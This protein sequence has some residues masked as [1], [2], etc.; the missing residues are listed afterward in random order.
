MSSVTIKKVKSRYLKDQ[1]SD[2]ALEKNRQRAAEVQSTIEQK[3]HVNSPA[4]TQDSNTWQQ[5]KH[6]IDQFFSDAKNFLTEARTTISSPTYRGVM[7]K[8]TRVAD[9]RD[10]AER[11]DTVVSYLNKNRNFLSEDYYN[12]AMAD[13]QTFRKYRP[14][15]TDGLRK[16]QDYFSQFETEDV[17]NQVMQQQKDYTDM[18]NYDTKAGAQEI[19]Q[20]EETLKEYNSLSRLNLSGKWQERFDELTA[21][22]GDA[23]G[24]KDLIS[25]KR[26]YLTQAQRLQESARLGSVG[27]VES[28][29]YDPS[30]AYWAGARDYKIPTREQLEKYDTMMDPGTW[31]FTDDGRLVDS[32]GNEIDHKNVDASG[33][34]IHPAASGGGIARDKLGIFLAAT[35]D[36]M[37]AA[38][39]V[40]DPARTSTWS[41]IITE[42]DHKNWRHLEPNEVNTYYYYLNKEGV[43]AAERYLDSLQD[44]LNYREGTAKYNLM[45]GKTGRE[46]LYGVEAGLDQ[47]AS[48]LRGVGN[49]ARGR[50]EYIPTT[51]TQY[52]SGMVRE[53]LADNGPEMPEWLGG[54]S[55]GQG[56]YDAITTTSNML[57]SILTSYAANAV[58]PGSGGVIGTGLL[59]ASAGGNAYNEM[60]NR[61]YDANQSRTYA[62][63]IGASE[64]GLQAVLGGISQFGGGLMS[65][66]IAKALGRVDNAIAR[67]AIKLGNTKIGRVLINAIEEGSEE[68]VQAIIE[69]WLQNVLLG[70]ENEID[71]LSDEALYSS[72]LGA[73]TGGVFEAGGITVESA[74][75]N[76]VLGDTGKAIVAAEGGVDALKD[77]AAD[78]GGADSKLSKQAEKVTGEQASGKGLGVVSA[79]IK[80]ATNQKKVGKLYESVNDEI[81]Q[82]NK[83]D[84]A[85][86]LKENGYSPSKAENIADAI[87]ASLNGQGLN[88]FQ[89]RVLESVKTDTKVDEVISS[90]LSDPESGIS[91]RNFNRDLYAIGVATGTGISPTK[92]AVETVVEDDTL[93]GR[94]KKYGE[95]AQA[96]M[97]TYNGDQDVAKF[98]QAYQRAYE[99]GQVGAKLEYVMNS[100]S[101]EYLTPQQRELAYE[102]GLAAHSSVA[103]ASITDTIFELNI[104][105]DSAATLL[106]SFETMKMSDVQVQEATI[107]LRKAYEF[108]TIG[109]KA[110]LDTNHFTS[111]LTAEQRQLAYN[112]GL[113]VR[114]KNTASRKA[115]VEGAKSVSGKVSRK[116]GVYYRGNDMSVQGIDAFTEKAAGLSDMQKTAIETMKYMSELIGTEFYVYESYVRNGKRY[117]I[118]ENGKEVPD[119]PNGWFDKATGKIYIDLHAGAT[120]RGTM[121]FT[122]AHE[123]THFIRKMSPEKFDIL[124]DIVINQSNLSGDVEMRINEKMRQAKKRGSPIDRDTAYEEVVADS[125]ETILTSGR[126]MEM[127]T[128]IKQQDK[129]LWEKI[130]DWFKDFVDYLKRVTAAY[131]YVDPDSYEGK[132]VAE[133]ESVIREL[134]QVFA[135]GLVDAGDNY[136]AIDLHNNTATEGRNN[137]LYEV[138]DSFALELQAWFDSTTHEAR[139]VSG[140]RF[141]V[142]T[143][144]KTLKSIGVKD[145]SIY[146]GGSKIDKI[147]EGNT[148]MTLE[149]IADAVLLLDDPILI[150]KSLTVEDSIVLFGEVYTSG[151][152]PVMISVLLSPKTKSGE[153]LDYAVIT[154]AYGRTKNNLQN[155][156]NRAKIYYV[157]EQKNRTDNWLKAL[158]LQLPS[159]ITKFGP[160]NTIEYRPETVKSKSNEEMDLKVDTKTESVAPAILKSERT[161][162]PTSNKG[163]LKQQATIDERFTSAETRD[164]QKIGRKSI[165]SFSSSDIK[166]TEKLAKRYWKEMG[167]KSPFFRA[168]FGDWRENDSTLI[169]VASDQGD[170]R[171][172]QKNADTG[173]NIQVSGKVFSETKN[174]K[175]SYNIAA[176]PYLPYINDIVRKAV[177]LDTWGFDQTEIKS[178]N[179]LLMHSLYAVADIG[180]GPEVL[181]LYVEEMNDPKRA[182][183]SKRA[184]QLQNVEKYRPAGKSSQNSASSI[185]PAA[186][187]INTVADLFSAVKLMDKNFVPAAPSTISNTNGTPKIVYHGTEKDFDVFS[188]GHIGN[189]TGTGILGD[190]FYFTDKKKLAKG[191][192]K[193][194]YPVYLQMKNPYLATESDVYKLRNALQMQAL[195]YDG[196]IL[197]APSGDIYMV[198]DNTQIKSAV[199]NIGTFDGT[200]SSILKS[201][202]DPDSVST[203]SLLAN[204]LESVA[205]HEV[206][207]KKLQEYKAKI[208]DVE[209]REARLQE[210]YSQLYPGSA[211]MPAQ[212]KRELQQEAAKIRNAITII[213]KQLF[214]L[215][216][217][218]PLQNVLNR[219]RNRVRKEMREQVKK[220]VAETKETEKQRYERRKESHAKTEMRKKIRKVIRDIDKLLSHGNKKQNVK[221][222]M[223]SFAAS[224]LASAEVLFMD[225]YSN[226]DMVLNGI[227]IKTTEEENRLLE[228]TESLLR[229]RD[230]LYTIS[231]IR[232]E[233][234]DVISGDTRDFNKRLKATE[235]LDRKISDNMRRLKGVFERERVRLNETTISELLDNLAREYKK[236]GLSD[237]M[238]IRSVT[239]EEV[240]QY[241]LHLSDDVAGYTVRDMNEK[242]LQEVYKAY[243]MVLT[244]VRNANKMFNEN[245][246][247]TAE[248]TAKTLISELSAKKIPDK[249]AKIVAKN[250]AD[251][252]GWDYEKLHYALERVGS[253]TLTK[254]FNNLANSEN[255]VMQ[256][257]IEA[258]RF[259][260]EMVEKYKYNDWKINQKIDRDFVDNTGKV[261]RLTLGELLSLYAYSRRDKA[262]NHIEY[263][264]FT[265]GKTAL[266]D[267]APANTYK[268]T[269]EQCEAITNT[270]TAEQKAF[271]EE[272]QSFLSDVMG[273]K[274]NEVSLKMYGIEMFG[275]KNYFP[276]HIAGQFKTAAQESKAKEEAGFGNIANAG[277][278]KAQNERAKEPFILEGFLDVWVDHVNEM[279][280]YHGTV[281]ALED[282]RKIMNFS[283]FSDADNDSVSVKAVLTNRFGSEATQYFMDLY[284]EANNGAI[285]DKLQKASKTML[286]KFRKNAVAYSAS[287]LI[288]QPASIHR[289]YALIDHKYFGWKGFGTLGIGVAKAVTNKW[290]KA[291]AKAYQEMLQYAPGVTMAKE[292]GG[293]D[294]AS[295]NTIRSYLMDTGKSLKQSF[296]TEN[297]K[298][299]VKA[300]LNIVDD[301]VIANLPNVAD[302][303]AWIEIWNACKRETV[304]T[305]QTLAPGSQEFLKK[306]GERFTEVIRATQVY[307]SIFAKSPLLK[308]KNLAVQY[309]VSFMNEPNTTVNMVESA[310]RAA[311]KGNIKKAVKT[312]NA[313]FHSMISV[314]L[315]KSIIYA[316]RDDEEDE[317]L[318]EKYV[319]SFVE[320]LI[321]DI[322]VFNYIPIAKDAWSAFYGFKA[323]R[324]DMTIINAAAVAVN[325]AAKLKKQDTASMSGEELAEWDQKVNA[326]NWKLLESISAFFCPAKTI[327]MEID[328]ILNLAQKKYVDNGLTTWLSVEDSVNEA[329]A[330][331]SP[332]FAKPE[333]KSITDKLYFAVI[334]GDV[335]YANRLKDSYK[336]EGAY[337]TAIRKGLKDNDA[338][339][340]EAALEQIDGHPEKRVKLQKE[341]IADG[342]NQ[343]DIV[344]ATNSIVDDLTPD[345]PAG[346]PKKKGWYTADD[347]VL[348]VVDG[349]TSY[350]KEAK[351]DIIATHKLN[352]KTDDE[353]AQSF[354][355]SAKTALKETFLSGSLT[356]A[357]AEHALKTYCGMEADDAHTTVNKWRFFQNT[358]TE[359]G[360]KKEEFV[361]GNISAADLVDALVAVEG[362]TTEEAHKTV[363][364]Y[365]RDAY[366]NGDFDRN[367]S[368]QIMM[369]YGDLTRNEAESKLRYIDVKLQMPDTYVNDAWVDEYYEEIETSG[370]PIDVFID[371]RTQV[372]GIDGD[373]KKQ[374]RMAVINSMPLSSS[375]KD[376]LYYAEGWAASTIY[377]APWH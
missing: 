306:A 264:G 377:Q 62:A 27:D 145:Y 299:K 78:V 226:E 53:D 300:A 304:I 23:K 219:E 242:Q 329:I 178:E 47:F 233:V 169:Q 210:I 37:A 111:K 35:E 297:T 100:K 127:M 153:I 286:S 4:T 263:G 123:L 8:T 206:E 372:K 205:Q 117:Y 63:L 161:A 204:A 3:Y 12:S 95:Q 256:D 371:Y 249:K 10:L 54:E 106:S 124:A 92:M 342:F 160:I 319:E 21:E 186:G 20:L 314:C 58:L 230:D 326:A 277:F 239:N 236:L 284:R 170:I 238:F 302:K 357:A 303:I 159:A 76:A 344:T 244:T 234:E 148:S 134:E 291:H 173:W 333:T 155:M 283:M 202:R 336:D 318:V 339:V 346:E 14:Q 351:Q 370:I 174:H 30:F 150:M 253:E 265:F 191:Y 96:M 365:T 97:A 128:E 129:T 132:T 235:K 350:A 203:R 109:N 40:A 247:Q 349:K 49:V 280:R 237:D 222:G 83:T 6:Y 290:T 360:D 328:A 259:R 176:R 362:K 262:W 229:Q 294:T 337:R 313:V 260:D 315:L 201:N 59:S 208:A 258:A 366:E 275:E 144:S 207:L 248:Q 137:V 94:S 325:N 331:A 68:Y 131:K 330:A 26:S 241:L 310:I 343:D 296:E 214:R 292:I 44:T 353:A 211:D 36:D 179:S 55:V 252:V 171:G 65:K 57:P 322:T 188:Y 75:K 7:G 61:G 192:G 340:Y 87:V 77:L 29:H 182:D 287:V 69:P 270:L 224:A 298:G 104:D 126:V 200:N 46:M 162:E 345:E 209:A 232:G 255:I 163:G 194:V 358:N 213:D 141:L 165:Y 266:T 31:K 114:N 45:E 102:A 307:D 361:S 198:Y 273:G 285:T 15:L 28:E 24:I 50:E 311:A 79:A 108:G 86:A 316:I 73:I 60:I 217:T 140:K 363:V 338:R 254:L 367:K 91:K 243:T 39:A 64:A 268:L 278:T 130:C 70:E 308:S 43:A 38:S 166:A 115:A 89:L 52:A 71:L 261:F 175:D 324:P 116:G 212:Q 184:Y 2:E 218:K 167:T 341:V 356:A 158:G 168:W 347:F 282:I 149:T 271:A 269:R 189:A 82:Q 66:G 74:Q 105:A 317:T 181:K 85:A 197:H 359:Y 84:I 118:N 125:M 80:N 373:G 187:N 112:A 139:K 90:V 374:R 142:G 119:A 348:F 309:L 295:G 369:S 93:E 88:K 81:S 251:M 225:N 113:A 22:Y 335:V 352:G 72:L 246:K 17:Y 216:A 320:S 156:I 267:P 1:P 25:Q 16:V 196:V 376:A 177:L 221:E 107:G 289:A 183:T 274:G 157:N 228:E 281:P 220:E 13:I 354:I 143:T 18:L 199:S 240:Y 147:L 51:A 56:A 327:R 164:I 121:L 136:Q 48:G 334:N 185:S 375:Q 332:G 146:M 103:E 190:G 101:V 245:I 11:A 34:I 364:D 279:S 355:S 250:L 120:G 9:S 19:A 180:K 215:E 32:Y 231:S 98:D 138:R 227:G 133:I 193:N 257:V 42:G 195:G 99:Y 41:G 110:E 151:Q 122:I 67:T 301:N 312:V 321:K 323:E 276:V 172:I 288:Q 154:S 152:K 33:K 293:F 5:E 305:H 272:M 368:M 223:K 135:E